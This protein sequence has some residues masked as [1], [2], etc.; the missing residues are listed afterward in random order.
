MT[1]WDR[2]VLWLYLGMRDTL[3]VGRDAAARIF[4]QAL[5]RPDDP[6]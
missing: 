3:P 2:F 5:A 4:N 1:F 6:R